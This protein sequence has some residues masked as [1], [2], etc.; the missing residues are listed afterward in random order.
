[1][2]LGAVMAT[3]IVTIYDPDGRPV[4]E[5]QDVYANADD[6]ARCAQRLRENLARRGW[7]YTVH[8]AEVR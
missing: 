2:A 3:Y 8:V 5:H 1:M 6:A 4:P 7:A